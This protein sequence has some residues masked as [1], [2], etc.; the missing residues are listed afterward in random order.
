M[1]NKMKR[2]I[3][4]GAVGFILAQTTLAQW[5]LTEEQKREIDARPKMP[6]AIQQEVWA[7]ATNVN[8]GSTRNFAYRA[9]SMQKMLEEADF[10]ADRLNLPTKRPIQITD[11]QYPWIAAPWFSVIHQTYPQGTGF[12]RYGHWP[13]T[14][15]TTN[16]LRPLQKVV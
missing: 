4:W 9:A 5:Q 2:T 10:F 6:E 12:W 16:N 11:I 15:Y 1:R 3:Y 7:M 8:H 13:S 14:V